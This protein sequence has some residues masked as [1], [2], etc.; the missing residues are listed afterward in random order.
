MALR[1]ALISSET[2]LSCSLFMPSAAASWSVSL[3]KRSVFV[4]PSEIIV[5]IMFAPT[6]LMAKSM[7]PSDCFPAASAEARRRSALDAERF[8]STSWQSPTAVLVSM[9]LIA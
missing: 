5:E 9:R 2:A 1:E 8:R 6:W 4:S 3:P 7:T